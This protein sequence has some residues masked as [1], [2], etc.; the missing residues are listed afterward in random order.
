MLRAWSVGYAYIVEVNR[1]FGRYFVSSFLLYT[2]LSDESI[3]APSE[4]Q[5]YTSA[6]STTQLAYQTPRVIVPA[7]GVKPTFQPRAH[8]K[9]AVFPV[10]G[11]MLAPHG[12]LYEHG[13]HFI[14][15]PE[16]AA[17]T[18]PMPLELRF[19]SQNEVG[20]LGI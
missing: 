16:A 14:H 10:L 2:I 19:T 7:L 11:S 3:P 15:L 17:T 9:C 8:D 12:T 18:V 5:F 13:H 4:V 1:K 20:D 6:H